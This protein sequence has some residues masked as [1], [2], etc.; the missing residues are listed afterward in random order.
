MN[1]DK[2]SVADQEAILAAEVAKLT[3]PAGCEEWANGEKLWLGKMVP[4]VLQATAVKYGRLCFS[5]VMMSGIIS[6][7]L[8]QQMTLIRL[9]GSKYQQVLGQTIQVLQKHA[10][11][12]LVRI[13]NDNEISMETFNECKAEVE[14]IGVLA[15]AAPGGQSPSGLILPH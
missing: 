9:L 12:L 3:L 8:G 6:A 7:A 15:S 1:A 2:V 10:N 13:L 11:D 14:R 5:L 4:Q